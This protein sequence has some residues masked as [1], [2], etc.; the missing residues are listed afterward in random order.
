MLALKKLY[1][2]WSERWIEWGERIDLNWL[3]LRNRLARAPLVAPGGPVVSLTSH[4]ARIAQV[5]LAI[6][7]IARGQL[8]PAR[9][10]LWLDDPAAIAVLPPTLQRQCAR[11]LE[12]RLCENFGPHTKYYPYLEREQLAAPLVTADDDVIYPARWLRELAA[13]HALYPGDVVCHR[14]RAIRFKGAALDA[15][16]HWPMCASTAASARHLAT[17]VCGVLYPLPLQLVLRQAGRAFMDCCPR[18]DDLWLHVVAVR[19]GHRIRQ[20]STTAEHFPSIPGSQECALHLSNMG[21][22]QNDVQALATYTQADLLLLQAA[23]STEMP[24]SAMQFSPGAA[25]AAYNDVIK[26]TNK[27]G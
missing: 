14:A 23:S 16:V 24:S 6:E 2:R 11:G 13:H 18:C 26:N 21:E 5:H 1:W 9:L 15:Y 10:I 17:G 22:G 25:L 8:L 12:V 7:S 4:G 27:Q 20:L 19:A 3:G